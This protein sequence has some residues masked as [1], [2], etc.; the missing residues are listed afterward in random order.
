[1]DEPVTADPNYKTPRMVLFRSL[2][3][4]RLRMASYWMQE[5]RI[6][7]AKLLFHIGVRL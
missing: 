3:G 6:P 5:H 2:C 7:G 1:M 4:W